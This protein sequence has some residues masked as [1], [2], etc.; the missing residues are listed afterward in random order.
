MQTYILLC[1]QIIKDSKLLILVLLLVITDI[2]ILSAWEVFDPLTV[3][4]YNKTH[5]QQPDPL[6]D[7]QVLIPQTHFCESKYMWYYG[8]LLCG[9]KGEL[10]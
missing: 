3:K 1:F 10:S 9:I 4:F 7:N 5:E 6:N 2:I 8:G